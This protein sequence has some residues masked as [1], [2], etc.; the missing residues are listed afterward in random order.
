M[1]DPAAPRPTREMLAP[2]SHA[3]LITRYALGVE[4]FDARVL[5][6][7]DS[8]LDTAFRPEANVGRWPCRVLLGHLADAEIAFTHRLRRVVGE[9]GPVFST[10]DEESFLANHLYGTGEAGPNATSR[11]PVAAFVAVIHSQRRWMSEW[12][13]TLSDEQWNRR[14]MHPQRGEQ[15]TRIIL[16]YCTFHLEHHAWYLN[17]KVRKFG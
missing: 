2:L 16:E 8:E 13:A 14:A 6:L 1:I 15:T 7:A 10:W 5:K 11:H 12:L 17:A 9:E 3:Q 4:N